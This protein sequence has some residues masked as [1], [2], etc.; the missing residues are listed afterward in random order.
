MRWARGPCASPD[1]WTGAIERLGL[2]IGSPVHAATEFTLSG[3]W[4]GG[5][6][7]RRLAGFVA[8]YFEG[9]HLLGV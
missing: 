7:N 5:F 9:A 8:G 3:R 6:V 2:L 1:T 4:V